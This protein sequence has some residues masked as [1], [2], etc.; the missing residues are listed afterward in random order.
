MAMKLNCRSGDIAYVYRV[1][2][3]DFEWLL[4]P[5]KF[6]TVV[7]LGFSKRGLPIWSLEQPIP[8]PVPCPS[9]GGRHGLERLPDKWLRPIRAGEGDDETITWAGKPETINQPEGELV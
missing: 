2:D 6:V 3:P 5:Q 8:S 9:C 1:T 7:N 4:K